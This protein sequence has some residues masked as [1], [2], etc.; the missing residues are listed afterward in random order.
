MIERIGELGTAKVKQSTGDLDIFGD[1]R[2][3]VLALPGRTEGHTGLLVRLAGAGD[4]LI[5]GDLYHFHSEISSGVVSRSNVSR[6]YAS[7]A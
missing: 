7:G 1:G 5:S 2:V 4:V 6:A 3:I